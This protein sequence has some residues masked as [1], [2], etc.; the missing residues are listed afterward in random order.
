M[1]KTESFSKSQRAYA[2]AILAQV[3]HVRG[4]PQTAIEHANTAIEAADLWL[5]RFIRGNIYLQSGRTAEAA[6]D[7][8]LCQQ[9]IGEGMA[10]FLNDRPSLRYM[11]DLEASIALAHAP[12]T[13]V[14]PSL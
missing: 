11:R 5:I 12:Q 8:L 14:S 7:L 1:G 3:A 2:G 4:Q 10:V 6:A 13:A 9:R